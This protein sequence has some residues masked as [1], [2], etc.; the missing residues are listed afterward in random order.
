MPQVT[1]VARVLVVDDDE[2]VR[3]FVARSLQEAGYEVVSAPASRDALLIVDGQRRFD[4]Y[5]LDV[6]MPGITGDE[7]GRR[8]RRRDP[9]AKVLYFTGF[10][11][12]LFGDSTSLGAHEAFLDKPVTMTGLCEAVSLLL[13]GRTRTRPSD[14][15]ESSVTGSSTPPGR[16][17]HH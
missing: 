16:A 5:I 9:D 7:L 4:V 6:M 1:P 14:P 3:T 15:D 2:A 10:A 8:V 11:D 17:S 12:R 13:F